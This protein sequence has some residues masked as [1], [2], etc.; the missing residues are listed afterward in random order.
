MKTITLDFETYYDSKSGYTL[1]KMRTEDY[2]T[3]PRF[4]M[5]S[6][7]AQ[8]ND[9]PADWFSGSIAET[10]EWLYQYDLMGSALCAHKTMFDG[11][12]LAYH[13]DIYPAFYCDTMA[14][15]QVLYGHAVRSVSLDSLL[16]YTKLGIKGDDVKRADG[17]RLEDFSAAELQQYAGVYGCDDVRNERK[18]F[19]HMRPKMH[20]DELRAIDQTLRMYLQPSLILNVDTFK[21]N[22]DAVQQKKSAILRELDEIGITPDLLRSNPKFAKVLRDR[23]IEPPM[24]PSVASVKR[25]DNPVIMTYAFGKGD[26]EFLDL[27]EEFEGDL[28]M[29]MIF[30]GRVSEKSTAEESRTI[31]F[32]E[33][34]ERHQKLRVP[35]TY[36][37]AHTLRYGGTEGINMQNPPR[38]SKSRMRFGIEA[39][40]GYVLVVSDLSQ[41][42]VRITAAL[43][44]QEDLLQIFRDGGDPYSV[45]AT[46][47]FGVLV[48][49]ASA[50]SNPEHFRMR[51]IAKASIL[52][53]GYGMGAPKFQRA[54]RTGDGGVGG[55]TVDLGTVTGY[56][57]FYREKYDMIPKLWDRIEAA[58]KHVLFYKE[59]VQFGPMKIEWV[60]GCIAATGPNGTRLWYPNL[61]FKDGQFT[62]KAARHTKPINIW[63]GFWAENFAQFLANIVIKQGALRVTKELDLWMKLQA[64]DAVGYVVPQALGNEYAGKIEKVLSQRPEWWPELPV[65]AETKIGLTYGDC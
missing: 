22:L 1:K 2:V 6:V 24:K 51:H 15:G 63:G 43:A 11:L 13:F 48:T 3:D 25:G 54:L 5:I 4:Q 7:Q 44:G 29:E 61:R 32:I 14:M 49:K 20:S 12:I 19:N 53:L 28:E 50:K 40:P 37:R 26:P 42:E 52:G 39:P 30:N 65:G 57:N 31:K 45:Y 17:K 41:I 64:H 55:L 47:L 16:K 8:I 62:F 58:F 34:G 21:E 18:L 46:E 56:V 36:A 23:G 10:K 35:L 38:V 33:I 59:P 9:G 60:D 27:R